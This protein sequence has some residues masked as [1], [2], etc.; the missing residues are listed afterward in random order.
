MVR[1]QDCFD[2]EGKEEEEEAE[3]D[4]EE[5][6]LAPVW[7]PVLLLFMTSFTILSFFLPAL[8][9]WKSGQSY[10]WFLRP[11]VTG[12]HLFDAGLAGGVHLRRF[13]GR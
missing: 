3:E 7:V 2:E 9:D 13:S 11:F 8:F 5:V 4:D 6:T 10:G 12:S 1:G